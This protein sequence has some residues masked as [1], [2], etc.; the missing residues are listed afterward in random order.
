MLHTPM[1]RRAAGFTL[2]ELMIVVIVIGILAAI[3]IPSYQEYVRR[4][5]RAVVKA[6]L[7]EYAQRAERYHTSNNSYTGYALPTKVSPRDGGT[8]R[9]NLDYKGDGTSFTITATPQGTQAKDSCGKL[10]VDQANR[11]TADGGVASCW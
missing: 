8:T 11:K 6:D 5:H 1:P 7:A 10:S 2:I 3:A 4:S 9:Y